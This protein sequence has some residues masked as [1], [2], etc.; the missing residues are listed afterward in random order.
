M[1]S[2][3][4]LLTWRDLNGSECGITLGGGIP[5]RRGEIECIQQGRAWVLWR[6]N[7]APGYTVLTASDAMFKIRVER[8]TG[9]LRL[10][11]RPLM[12]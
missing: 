10:R 9:D 2:K 11:G 12:G 3:P 7:R 6:F 8:A 1:L 5:K 4:R